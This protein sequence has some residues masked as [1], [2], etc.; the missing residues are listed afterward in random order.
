MFVCFYESFYLCHLGTHL[1]CMYAA[2]LEYLEFAI[3]FVQS[4][5]DERYD[6]PSP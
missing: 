5:L 3:A 1:L 4:M 6:V 2:A